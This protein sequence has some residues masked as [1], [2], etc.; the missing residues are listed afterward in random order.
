MKRK[1]HF[2]NITALLL[3][4]AISVLVLF[5]MLQSMEY[6]VRPEITAEANNVILLIGDG[7]GFNHIAAA[8]YLGDVAMDLFEYGGSV[9]N[10]SL[11]SKVTDSA[12]AATAMATGVKT[13]NA[14][15]S[16][17][18]LKKVT[19]L[20]ELVKQNN[21]KLGVIST[22]SV[23]DAT[24]AAF[25]AHN[26]LRINQRAIAI[27]QIR[28]TIATLFGEGRKDFDPHA[29]AKRGQ[30]VSIHIGFAN[31]KAKAFAIFDEVEP[32]SEHN[33]AA[34][35]AVALEMLQNEDG[36]FLMVEGSKIDSHS[37]ANDMEKML[38]EF[39]AF[40]AAVLV[41]L[42]F[43]ADN[44]DT[45][46]IVTADHETGGLTLP[47]VLS[48]AAINDDCFTRG[49]H[50]GANVPFFAYGPGADQIPATIDNTDI[51]HI[52]KQLLF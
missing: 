2:R 47:E 11:S 45:T 24:P 19:N 3:V 46:V 44:P 50:S 15:I 28:Y 43:A 40:N 36:F 35:T 33:L 25:T 8:S 32:D 22:K 7:M 1:N 51:F 29:S 13:V 10:R 38:A 16:F 23:T 26:F 14:M 41:A 12:A 34:L 39:W 30:G 20:G 52:I 21:K 42:D 5:G 49:G 48:E 37:H 31:T 27:E 9:T 18:G 17:S 6:G 4:V